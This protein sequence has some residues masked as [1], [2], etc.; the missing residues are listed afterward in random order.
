MT[1]DSLNLE[2]PPNFRGL[3]PDVPVTM[4]T[5][6]LPH[7]RQDGATYWVTFRLADSLPIEKL[8]LIIS[9]RK[10]WEAKYPPPRSED[11]WKEY[12]KTVTRSVE[13]WLDQGSGVCHFKKRIFADELARSILHFQDQQYFVGGYVVMPNHCHLVIRPYDGFDLEDI[14]GSIKGVVSRAV[15]K[16]NGTN[17]ALWQQESFDRIIRDEAHLYHVIQ[18]IGNNPRLASLPQSMWYRWLHPQWEKVGWRFRDP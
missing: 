18:Y 14:L 15:N 10:H 6:H 12:V 4:Y 1:L 3:H 17:G 8:D 2:A 7:W 5:R 16:A 9:M 11:T 13:K